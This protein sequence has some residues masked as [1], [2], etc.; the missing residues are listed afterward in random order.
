[1][2]FT[3]H[4]YIFRDLIKTFSLATLVLSVVL[5]LGVM[6]RPLQQFSVDPIRVPELVLCTLPITLTMVIP[7]AALLAATLSYGRLAHDNEIMACRSSGI[8]LTTLIYPALAL[9]LLVGLAALLLGF[10]VIPDFIEHSE[11]IV[12]S[13]AEAII[14]RNI[15]KKG[16]LGREFF[17]GVLVHAD[18]ADPDRHLLSGVV[19]VRQKRNYKK[20]LWEIERVI[21]AQYVKLEFRKGEKGNKVLMRMKNA[22]SVSGDSF[23]DMD[24]TTFVYPVPSIFRDD[25]KF[26]KLEDLKAIQNDMTNFGP[27]RQMLQDIREGVTVESFFG[28]CQMQLTRAGTIELVDNKGARVIIHGGEGLVRK[29][30]EGAEFVGYGGEAIQVDYYYGRSERDGKEYRAAKVKLLV[31]MQAVTPTVM[32]QMEDV[33]WNYRGDTH[34]ISLSSH[35]LG[36]ILLP[37]EAIAEGRGIE[38]NDIVSKG[39]EGTGRYEKESGYLSGLYKALRR[40]CLEL[41]AEIWAQINSRLAF[42]VSCVVLTLMGAGLGIVFRSGHLLTAFGVSFVPA[43][44]CL[45]TI[46]TGQ[47]IAEQSGGSINGGIVFLWSG[48]AA[49]VV[50]NVVLYKWLAKC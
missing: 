4:R 16:E 48:I 3:L 31:D 47:H 29:G 7:I 27:I 50:G 41:E 22:R 28:W 6:L 38:L 25:I 21:T 20:K 23:F 36:G 19:I 2:V 24:D 34:V 43:A 40:E 8:G 30:N 17:P 44:L 42:G 33:L 32:V 39:S 1:M 46:F 13:D 10:H 12:Q 15:E 35:S 37:Q 45:I 18:N 26:K 14:Y 9:A 49:V 11:S 5:G